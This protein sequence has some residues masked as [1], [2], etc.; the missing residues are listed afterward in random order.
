MI[1]TKTISKLLVGS[2]L[3]LNFSI[4]MTHAVDAGLC[5]PS[6]PIECEE[7]PERGYVYGD[8]H[9]KGPDGDDFTFHGVNNGIYGIIS[10]D[11]W[12]INAK[13]QNVK[14]G[15]TN[16]IVSTS[17]LVVR[18]LPESPQV[19]F[20]L[21]K[22][23]GLNIVGHPVKN[24]LASGQTLVLGVPGNKHTVYFVK[25]KA[26]WIM[27]S[28]VKILPKAQLYKGSVKIVSILKITTEEGYS[29]EQVV[30]KNTKTQVKRIDIGIKTGDK[31]YFNGTL[32]KG[33]IGHLFDAGNAAVN[34]IPNGNLFKVANFVQKL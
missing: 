1:K 22:L 33:L 10:E 12:F 13:F 15:S 6:E 30:T 16:R 23:G 31:G 4:P 20:Y 9:F 25:G 34:V 11:H 7:Q 21:N 32:P 19:A 24:T 28:K 17:S 18:D 3:L 26:Q 5:L 2:A 14:A 8:P 29:V 27:K